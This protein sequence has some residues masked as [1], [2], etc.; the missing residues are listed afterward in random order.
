MI[1]GTPQRQPVGFEGKR[2]NRAK[3]LQLHSLLAIWLKREF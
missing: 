1:L 2:K 3:S